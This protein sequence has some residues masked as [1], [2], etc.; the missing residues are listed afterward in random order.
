MRRFALVLIAAIFITSCA[1]NT[2]V[3]PKPPY[4]TQPRVMSPA[5][6]SELENGKRLFKDGFYKRS[7][8]QLLPLAAEGNMEAQYAVGY[9]YYYGFGAAQDSASGA[10]WIQRAADQH[11]EPAVK[12]LAII[13]QNNKYTPKKKSATTSAVPINNRIGV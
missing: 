6:M 3:R 5:T 4:P 8:E 12:A 7:M 13:H 10:F 2:K 1:T 9:M 11:F